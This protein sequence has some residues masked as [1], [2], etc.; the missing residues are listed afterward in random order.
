MHRKF[1]INLTRDEAQ[2]AESR[3]RICVKFSATEPSI[4]MCVMLSSKTTKVE[5][6][7]V[8]VTSISGDFSMG[9]TLSKVDKPELMMLENSTYEELMERYIHLN[10]VYMD[11]KDTKPQLPIHLVLGASEYARI[12]V[13]RNSTTASHNF[14]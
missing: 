10:G 7:D 6:Y 9:V 3:A 1:Y 8:N 5:M 13:I 11:D 2:R 12:G 4:Y 14:A